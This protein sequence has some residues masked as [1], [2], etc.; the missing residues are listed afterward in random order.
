MKTV[1]LQQVLAEHKFDALITGIR[2]DEDPTRAKERYFSPRN[3]QE[4]A[5][6]QA[7]GAT[8]PGQVATPAATLIEADP[9]DPSSYNFGPTDRLIASIKGVGAEVIFRLGRSEGSNVE[10]PENLDHYAEVAKHI[11]LHYNRGWANG[12]RYGIRY[13]EVWNEPD[14][15]RVFWGGSAQHFFELYEKVARAVKK[16][17]R[18][19]LVGGPAIARPND[20]PSSFFK[21]VI[22]DWLPFLLRQRNDDTGTEKMRQ[23]DFV[24]ER[25]A[26]DDMGGRVDMGRVMH[27]GGDAL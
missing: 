21:I 7:P 14:L 27:G 18:R 13:W 15:G 3:A 11:V 6:G 12:Y 10:P 19:A 17:D 2:R 20:F 4:R 16:A 24:D 1:A 25:G 22:G 5:R 9:N 23:R 26:L 8:A